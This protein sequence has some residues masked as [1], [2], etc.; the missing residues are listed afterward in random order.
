MAVAAVL[1]ADLTLQTLRPLVA[2]MV[3]VVAVAALEP[4]TLAL[5]ERVALA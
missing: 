5:A 1:V 3:A 2:L 4:R